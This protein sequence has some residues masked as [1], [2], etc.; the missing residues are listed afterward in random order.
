MC[1]SFHSNYDGMIYIH[2][3]F[4]K[5]AAEVSLSS[6]YFLADGGGGGGGGVSRGGENWVFVEVGGG[7]VGGGVGF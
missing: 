7:Q 1:C 2:Y 3:I 6:E 5:A 4:F